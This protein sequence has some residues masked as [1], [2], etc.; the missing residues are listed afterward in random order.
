MTDPRAPLTPSDCD[1]RDFAFMPLQVERLRRSKAWLYAKRLPE[2][3]FYMVN[4]WATSWHE[5]P[6]ASV[7]DDD[8]VLADAAM[9]DPKR[10]PAMKIRVMHG[11]VKCSDGRLYH[12]VVAEKACEAWEAKRAQRH[13]TAAATAARTKKTSAADADASRNDDRNGQRHVERNGQRHD[14]VTFTKGQ[15]QGQGEKKPVAAVSSNPREQLLLLCEEM[16]IS[17]QADALRLNWPSQL[18]A[19]LDE[20]LDLHRH[21]IPAA[22]KARADGKA[23]TSLNYIKPHAMQLRDADAAA[24]PPRPIRY[25]DEAG[26]AKRLALFAETPIWLDYWGPPRGQPDH[27]C[28]EELWT[29]YDAKVRA[30]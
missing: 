30:A 21:L 11:W 1:L 10:W 14:D 19:M 26:W 7:E 15:G 25:T 17:F 8:D 5:V 12:P 29:K 6:C 9:C 28:P 22:R 27:L 13:R 2:L 4:L 18:K 23:P 20:G 16:G 24:N 3:G